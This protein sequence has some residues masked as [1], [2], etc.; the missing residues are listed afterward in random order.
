LPAHGDVLET[1]SRSAD[2]SPDEVGDRHDGLAVVV[3]AWV[4]LPGVVR[5]AILGAEFMESIGRI[6]GRSFLRRIGRGLPCTRGSP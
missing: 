6:L 1:R 3:E 5:G 2:D 4:K